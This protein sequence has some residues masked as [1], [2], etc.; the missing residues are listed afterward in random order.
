[1]YQIK[2]VGIAM[3]CAMLFGC[4]VVYGVMPQKEY[5]EMENRSLEPK[6]EISLEDIQAGEYQEQYEKYLSDQIFLRDGLVKLAVTMELLA[7]KRE[8]NHV[9]IGKDGYLLEKYD[10]SDFDAAQAEENISSLAGFLNDA[11]RMYGKRNVACMMLP[12]KANAMPDKLPGYAALNEEA[13]AVDGLGRQLEE[14]GVL[15]DVAPALR[16][17]QEEYIYYRTDHHW[18]TL[19]AYYAYCAW[20]GLT[21]HKVRPLEDYSREAVFTDFYGTTYNKVHI[22]VQP[23]SVELFHGPGEKG[24]KVREEGQDAVSDTFYFPKEAA[25]GFDRYRVFFSKNTSKMEIETKAG[26]KRRLLLIKD[27][28]ANC[29][30]PFL[31][32][33]YDKIIMIDCRYGKENVRELMADHEEITDVLVMYN[34]QKFLQD[35][36]LSLLNRQPDASGAQGTSDT[37]QEFHLDDFLDD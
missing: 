34:T 15:L 24:V 14:P 12:S 20:A 5:S 27:S 25:E 3:F 11:V 16:G 2:V 7:G 10:A 21:G 35:T 36:N 37:I 29:F 26:T 1:M 31:A 8:V 18:T 33:H 22:Q 9:Y 6:P 4:M 23:D 19:G 28:F 17:H 13:H 30:V 32:E